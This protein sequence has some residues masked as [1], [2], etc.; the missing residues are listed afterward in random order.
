[1]KARGKAKIRKFQA[2]FNAINHVFVNKSSRCGF[3]NKRTFIAESPFI[4]LSAFTTESSNR[5]DTCPFVFTRVIQ[6]LIHIYTENETPSAA[7]FDILHCS[8][9]SAS[10]FGMPVTTLGRARSGTR[11]V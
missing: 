8:V 11:R 1:M 2:I 10:T 3:N 9:D 5:I 6:T 4:S 7:A